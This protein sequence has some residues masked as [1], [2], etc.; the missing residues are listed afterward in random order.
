MQS[1]AVYQQ[2]VAPHLVTQKGSMKCTFDLF[3]RWAPGHNRKFPEFTERGDRFEK[4][5]ISRMLVYLV[6]YFLKEYGRWTLAII[7]DNR[8]PPNHI[9]H[10][11]LKMVRKDDELVLEINRL[12]EYTFI[13]ERLPLPEWLSK[14]ITL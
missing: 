3:H 10:T 5:D 1:V 13:S 4:E 9:E 11:I 7:R 14:P 8:I 2:T 6:R 12:Q